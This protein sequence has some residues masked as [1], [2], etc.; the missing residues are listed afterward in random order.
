VAGLAGLM[1]RGP[2]SHRT[3]ATAS[4]ALAVDREPLVHYGTGTQVT[5]HIDPAKIGPDAAG[6]WVVHL[7]KVFVEPMGA[8]RVTPQ[9]IRAISDGAGLALTFQ[10]NPADHDDLVRIM[11]NPTEAGPQHLVV[12]VGG[13]QLAWTQWVLP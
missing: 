13:E 3:S 11:L 1:G 10:L 8:Q 2:F 9:P 6:D 7:N 4:G 12:R 5:L